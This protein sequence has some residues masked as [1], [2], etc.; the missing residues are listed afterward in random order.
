[1]PAYPAERTAAEQEGIK[2]LYLTAPVTIHERNGQITHLECLKTR[3]GKPGNDGRRRPKT[4]AGT[5]FILEVDR[6]I[7]AIGETPDISYMPSGVHIDGPLIKVDA[8]GRTSIPGVY[9]GGD[10]ANASWNV[11]EAIGSGKRAAIGIDLFLRNK[12]AQPFL[13]NM[14]NAGNNSLSFKR[15]IAGELPVNDTREA[16]VE[17]LNLYYFSRIP[18]T[19]LSS[20]LDIRQRVHTFDEISAGL[21]RQEAIAEAGRCFHCGNCNFCKTCYILC[22]DAAIACE[23]S[24]SLPT[25]DSILCKRCR[26]CVHE[27]PRGVIA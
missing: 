15:Y 14:R 19:Q 17:D 18:R 8:L 20:E 26:I 4:I 6:V 3:L 23:E 7:T 27:C 25:I 2:I 1:M 13:E 16:A 5:N 22:P 24:S 12:D 9:A 11:A 21:S 10:L